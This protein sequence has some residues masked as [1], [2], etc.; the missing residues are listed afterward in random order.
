VSGWETRVTARI[1]KFLHGVKL[2]DIVLP[3]V[4]CYL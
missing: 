4:D 3:S 1:N 2:H